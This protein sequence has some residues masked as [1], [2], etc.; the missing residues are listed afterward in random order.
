[1]TVPTGDVGAE[2]V[3]HAATCARRRALKERPAAG[4]RAVDLA[5][6]FCRQARG[7]VDAKSA[8]LSHN[9]DTRTYRWPRKCCKASIGARRGMVE[10]SDPQT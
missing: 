9:A 5:D 3:C 2:A 7:R 4:R 1:V 8:K 6:V 10:L